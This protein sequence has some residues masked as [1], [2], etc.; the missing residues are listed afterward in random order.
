[1]TSLARRRILVTGGAGYIGSHAVRALCDLDADVVVLDSLYS[2]HHAAVDPRASFIPGDVRDPDAVAEAMV[3]AEAVLHFAALAL[4]GESVR[5]PLRYQDVNVRGTRT[6][7][8]AAARQGVSAFVL[9]STAATYGDDVP[10]PITEEQPRRPCNPYGESKVAAEDVLA[11]APFP[12]VFLRYFNAAGASEDGALGEDHEPETHLVPLAIAAVLGR[13]P[14]LTVFGTDWPTRDGT[15]VR[16]YVHVL[17]LVDAHVRALVHL[18]GGGEGGAFNLGTGTGSTVREVLAAVGEVAGTAVPAVDGERRAG[19]PPTLVASAE[20]ARRVLGW[21]PARG[22]RA[23]VAD[24]HRW[25]VGH[26][27]GYGD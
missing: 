4:V 24:A 13:R 18:L 3:D 22:L 11:A 16:D 2:G 23:I 8:E 17:D 12:A 15:C 21:S 6:L 27:G 14:P 25:H 26:P 7:A 20:R 19:D 10:V 9:S 5:E 1:M